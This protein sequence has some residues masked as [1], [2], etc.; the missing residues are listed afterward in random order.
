MIRTFALSAAA[1]MQRTYWLGWFNRDTLG[2]Q[3]TDA[4]GAKAARG[5]AYKVA[6]SWM[7]GTSF[8]GCRTVDPGA[9]EGA[10]HLHDAREP[11]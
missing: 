8:Q 6:R 10:A 5:E 4:N 11:P 2:V 7:N 1:G 3:M 9:D